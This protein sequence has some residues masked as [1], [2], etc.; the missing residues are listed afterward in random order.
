LIGCGSLLMAS[1]PSKSQVVP[2]APSAEC[3]QPEERSVSVPS[4]PAPI[5]TPRADDPHRTCDGPYF[6]FTRAGARRNISRV[7]AVEASALGI[8]L[9]HLSVRLRRVGCGAHFA[10]VV[11]GT[12]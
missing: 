6:L 5:A 7:V 11:I 4:P 1:K 12:A 10:G 9:N 3:E 8:S 2:T